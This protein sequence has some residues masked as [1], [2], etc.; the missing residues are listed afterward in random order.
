[1]LFKHKGDKMKNWEKIEFPIKNQYTQPYYE[2][3]KRKWFYRFIKRGFDVSASLVLLIILFFPSILISILVACDSR[4]GIF[5][6]QTR[7][8]RFGKPFKIIK[9]RTMI[10]NSEGNN[11]ITSNNDSRIT[12]I[13][14]F[15]RKTH[16]D[17][18]PQLL[19]VISGQ[20]SFVGTRPEVKKYVDLYKDEWYATL[21]MRPG[22]T[23]T[24]SYKC[25]DEAKYM[26]RENAH[27]IYLEKVLPLKMNFNLED[28]KRLSIF[29]DIKVLW[30]TLF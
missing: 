11:Q 29:R 7:V 16:I 6:C 15:L 18:F 8:G 2:H 28:I 30:K 22:I 20:M 27:D 26:T 19:N 12:K 13:G 3:I 21:L 23:S 9:F 14:K 1:M 4:G 10:K 5:F 24:A 25:D 17:E